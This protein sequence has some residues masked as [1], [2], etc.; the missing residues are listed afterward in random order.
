[1]ATN[2]PIALIKAIITFPRLVTTRV[3]HAGNTKHIIATSSSDTP[4]I[5][6]QNQA[7]PYP[8]IDPTAMDTYNP[9]KYVKN[10]A[11]IFEAIVSLY[12]TT[13]AF[14]SIILFC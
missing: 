2:A 12:G 1:M 13:F 4:C 11:P 9:P 10:A 3:K 7:A 6:I 8:P 5:R 14:S